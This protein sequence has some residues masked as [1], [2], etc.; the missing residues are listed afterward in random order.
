MNEWLAAAHVGIDDDWTATR[1]AAE[2]RAGDRVAIWK[3]GADGGICAL[4]EI[5]GTEFERPNAGSSDVSGPL[6]PAIPFRATRFID[7]L[8]SRERCLEHPVLRG[9]EVLRFP[10]ATN[11]R[12]TREQWDA[13]MELL[14][15][16]TPVPPDLQPPPPPARARLSFE[17]LLERTL[18][19]EPSLRDL[20][21]TLEERRQVIL[22]GPPGTGKTWVAESI[23]QYL[24]GNDTERYKTVQFHPSYT[25]EE[26]VVG[27][28]PAPKGGGLEFVPMKGTLAL[29]AE[30]AV[31]TD[32]VLVID[33]MNRA[34]LPRVFGELLY[35]LE[36]RNQP[37]DLLYLKNF[38]LP[39]GLMIIGT[40]NTADRSIRTIDTA[41]RRRFE[42]F[43]CP[44][45]ADALARYYD[46]PIRECLVDDLVGGFER[47]NQRLLERLDKYHTIGHT[48]FMDEHFTDDRLRRVW[49]RQLLPLLEEYFFDQPDV[50]AEF[51]LSEFWPNATTS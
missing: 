18:W 40:M 38:T 14:S 37:L 21:Q 50:V 29:L 15:T 17:W 27:L 1:Y 33:E 20:L 35:L 24:T 2:M 51:S 36:Y 12:M 25:Y 7:P 32:H 28:R 46:N 8:I 48:F 43:D 4:G 6:E 9:L 47:L 13:V 34:N 31:V 23:A 19:P 30:R 22:A 41:L 11:Y 45:D 16:D 39:R 49:N 10:Q 44:P 42:I 26:F 5:T 3:S